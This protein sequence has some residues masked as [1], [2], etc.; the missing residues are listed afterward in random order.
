MNSFK[1][2]QIKKQVISTVPNPWKLFPVLGVHTAGSREE[3]T[4]K[5]N[6]LSVWCRHNRSMTNYH[7]QKYI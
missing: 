3:E 2:N 6:L 7:I 5:R 1:L 4:L